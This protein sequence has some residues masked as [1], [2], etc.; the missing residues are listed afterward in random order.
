MPSAL[1]LITDGFEE[2]ETLSPVD[3][4]RR[5]GVDV[6][7]ASLKDG[8][9]VTG[10]SG[11]TIHADLPLSMLQ[12]RYSFDML[13]LPGGPQ[14]K[15]MRADGR[16]MALARAYSL[17]GKW[18][19][20]ICAAPRV[21]EDAALLTGKAF[22]CF[23]GEDIPGRSSMT[24][25]VKDGRLITATAAGSSLPFALALVAALVSEAKAAEIAQSIVYP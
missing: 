25:V 18:I 13:V 1:V 19:A 22:T 4:L 8:I 14:V 20:A 11:I 2:M 23:P 21:L 12:D 6:T 15:A 7:I 24:P 3:V 17:A 10:R 5:A 9:H 16:A